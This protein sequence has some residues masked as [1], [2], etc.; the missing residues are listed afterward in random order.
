MTEVVRQI[1][2]PGRF[3]LLSLITTIAFVA[4]ACGGG[5]ADPT[6]T[7]ATTT[8][9]V[10]TAT[11]VSAAPTATASAAPTA[12]APNGDDLFALGER[13]FKTAAEN[14]IGCQ[15]CHGPDGKGLIG[16]D[17]RGRQI[18]EINYA[19]GNVGEMDF[20]RLTAEEKEAVVTYLAYLATQP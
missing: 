13:V 9:G 8:A 5:A 2:V 17:I 18:S 11:T 7:T 14:G 20:I 12:T 1:G 15:A 4:A 19:L 10:P 3:L 6:A 16:P